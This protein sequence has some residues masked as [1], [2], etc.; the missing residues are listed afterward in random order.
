MEKSAAV[1]VRV[2]PQVKSEAEEVLNKLGLSM[3]TAIDVFLRQIVLTGSI[4]FNISLPDS[5]DK[6]DKID[7]G[8]IHSDL[9]KEDVLSLIRKV[10]LRFSAIER[11]YLFGSFAR[12]AQ[13][14]KSDIDVRLVIKDD[15]VFTLRDVA[16]FAK[17]LEQETGRAVDVVTARVLKNESLSEAIEREKV[18]AYEC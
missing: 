12:D 10:S 15:A 16:Q 18:L 14:S 8:N 7:E 1:N 11:A 3:S 17:Q 2:N 5:T 4:P 9:S 6:D 13:T